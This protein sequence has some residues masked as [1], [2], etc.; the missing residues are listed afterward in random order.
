[1]NNFIDKLQKAIQPP[2]FS[3]F[4]V[5]QMQGQKIV[6]QVRPIL[7]QRI[8]ESNY[9]RVAIATRFLRHYFRKCK[10]N[11]I[12]PLEA[13]SSFSV[14][15]SLF[16]SG[17]SCVGLSLD[18]LHHLPKNIKGYPVAA[19]LAKHYQQF[20]GPLY[21]HAA[22]VI[23]FQDPE[24]NEKNGFILL[25]PSFHI[26][27]P[28][29][30]FKNGPS[31]V[32]DMGDKKG[33][34]TFSL[35]G[36]EIFCRAAPKEGSTSWSDEKIKDATMIYRTDYFCNPEKGYA[37]HQLP[38][39]KS[40]PIVS[41]KENGEQKAHINVDLRKN[42]IIWKIG[43]NKKESLTFADLLQGKI[44]FDEELY[45]LLGFSK[46]KFLNM[47]IA[48]VKNKSIFDDLYNDYLKLLQQYSFFSKNLRHPDEI[49]A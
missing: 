36:N 16:N 38:I 6:E 39:D 33:F 9:D 24:N 2:L 26:A 25:D 46:K 5:M 23:A 4:P 17:N 27:E 40:L 1:M 21:S 8:S 14:K 10:Q 7:K 42:E 37:I 20:A 30:L 3:S 41:R 48:I 49:R 31:V 19:I 34:W 47:I 45:S 29:L 35:E 43:N 28:I 11:N 18:L 44:T 15:S 32:I 12:S 22:A 13:L